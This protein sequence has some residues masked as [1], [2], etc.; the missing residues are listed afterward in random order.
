MLWGQVHCI[1]ISYSKGTYSDSVL[2]V[3]V[4]ASTIAIFKDSVEESEGFLG[5]PSAED[6]ERSVTVH[7]AGHLLGLVNLVYT[8]LSTMRMKITKVTPIMKIR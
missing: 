8:L 6:V 4:D 3:A 2:G 7:E 1:G 5:R